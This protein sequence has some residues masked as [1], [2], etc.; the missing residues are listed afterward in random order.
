MGYVNSV[1][2][3]MRPTVHLGR[4][5]AVALSVCL[6]AYA[7]LQLVVV[8]NGALARGEVGWDANLYLSFPAHWI[9]TGSMY[10]PIQMEGRY[11]AAGVVNLYPPI[12]MY[13]FAPMSVLP[14]VLWWAIPLGIIGW[15]LYR[16]RPAWWTWPILA[17][18]A[19]SVPVSA[20]LVYGNTEMWTTAAL[21]VACRWAPAALF[22]AIKPTVFPLALLFARDRRWWLAAGVVGLLALPFGALWLDWLTAMTNLESRGLLYSLNALPTLAIPLVAYFG[23]T[24]PRVTVSGA[25][26]TVTSSEPD[27]PSKDTRIVSEPGESATT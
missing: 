13:L 24:G 20:V 15:H 18:L 9:E 16:S 25:A 11:P 23:S 10:Y 17:G 21:A 7:L 2:I 22:L 6:L 8:Y 5:L 3:P 14:R 19:A 27:W 4:A 12:A 26:D 1:D